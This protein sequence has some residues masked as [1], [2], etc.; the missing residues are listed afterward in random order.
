MS[1]N[2]KKNVDVECVWP[3][4]K[5]VHNATKCWTWQDI[6]ASHIKAV[7]G[8]VV[9][10][11]DDTYGIL[12]LLAIGLSGAVTILLAE[13]FVRSLGGDQDAHLV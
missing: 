3:P 11:L 2:L 4:T 6:E 10:R 7:D 12:S 5:A 1:K 13:A 8:S 9:V